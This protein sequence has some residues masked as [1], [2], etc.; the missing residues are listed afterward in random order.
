MDRAPLFV[1]GLTIKNFRGY[2]KFQLE[3]PARACVVLLSGPNGLGKTSL[4]EALEWGLT[5]S[6]KRLDMLS[7]S[8]ADPMDLARR[9]EDMDA[10]EV[11]LSFRDAESREERITRTQLISV[12]GSPPQAVGTTVNAVAELLR[13]HEPHWNVTGKNVADYLHLTHFHPQVASLRLV[14]FNAKERWVRVSPLAGADRFERV[15]LNLTNSKAALTK[16]KDRRAE[17]LNEEIARLQRWTTRLERLTQLK[18]LAGA[19]RDLLTPKEAAQKILELRARFNFNTDVSALSS[20]HDVVVASEAI[21]RFRTAIEQA[22]QADDRRLDV[23]GQLRILPQEWANVQSQYEAAIGRNSSLKE[24]AA[25]LS[26]DLEGR[27]QTSLNLKAEYE[28]ALRLR[29]RT[30]GSHE[31]ITRALLDRDELVR[32]EQELTAAEEQLGE[33][34]RRLEEATAQLRR[35]EEDLLNYEG[36]L[37][38]RDRL[39]QQVG[40]IQRAN[41]ALHD[42]EVLQKRVAMEE[43]HR[44]SLVES[45][46]AIDVAEEA[47]KDEMRTSDEQFAAATR[48]LEE[49]QRTFA[50]LQKALVVIAEHLRNEDTTCPVC[51]TSFDSGQ[52]R[53]LARESISTLDPRLAKAESEVTTARE[54]REELRR[55][56]VQKGQER[57]KIQA[58]LRA[59]QESL[60]QLQARIDELSKDPFLMDFGLE[61]A[62]TQLARALSEQE[63]ERQ[64][65]ELELKEAGSAERLRQAVLESVIAADTLRRARMLAYERRNARQAGRAEMQARIEQFQAEYQILGRSDFS[66][67][68]QD[69]ALAASKA[70]DV[71]NS[72]TARFA[73][74]QAA[75]NTARQKLA[76]VN[77]EGT[78]A[79][80]QIAAL[81]SRRQTLAKQWRDAELSGPVSAI[82]LDSKIEEL[83]H[84]RRDFEDVLTEVTAIAAALDQW[85]QAADLQSL[86]QELRSESGSLDW[87]SFTRE[88]NETVERAQVAATE[89]Q[90]ARDAADQLSATLGRVTAD[91]GERALKP[92]DELFRRYLRALVHDERFHNIEATYEPAARS[93]GLRFRVE[94]GG[95]DTEAEYIL[96][97]GQLGEVSL[98][99]MLA[100]NSAFP[101]SRWRAL[102]LDDP[103]Q[104]NDLIHATALFD[105]LRNLVH[106]AGHQIF[107]STHDN[108][109]AGFFRRKLDSMGISWIECRFIAHSAD[110]IVTEIRTSGEAGGM[111]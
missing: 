65:V 49:L 31:L 109:Q 43:I 34:D 85:Q 11:K 9:T 96:S 71:A 27:A 45:L 19:I 98:A 82:V 92:F 24:D 12:S 63:T 100:A 76:T 5:G 111:G 69:A 10:I 50:E 3:V 47:L 54:A 35:R 44:I 60:A 4:F 61:E 15:R 73:E 66:R 64:R 14:T 88:L 39:Q 57:R 67:L 58:D 22:R 102:L 105:V 16:L 17:E 77:S 8:K 18:S 74:A 42:I 84:R 94:L 48:D 68:I 101:W 106:F 2:G 6:V 29:D 28:E 93:A 55:R 51:R 41:R 86:E 90:R 103:T 37:R 91:F 107:V 78:K 108:E 20:D 56:E 110:G 13:S 59:I 80:A 21:R 26:A 40:A 62:R 36:L 99:A 87:D 46:H 7:G 1:T 33:A 32:L 81:E 97:E 95:S 53:V 30:A 52:L 23:Y 89:A 72:A 79:K 83:G 75:E 70:K 104:Y 38:N 25:K